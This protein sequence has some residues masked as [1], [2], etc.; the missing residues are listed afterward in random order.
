MSIMKKK[1]ELSDILTLIKKKTEKITKNMPITHGW[2]HTALVAH[3]AQL[4]ALSEKKDTFSAEA[5]GWTHDWGRSIEKTDK[6]KRKH[7]KLSILLSKDFYHN[8][9]K[10]DVIT[11]KQYNDIQKAVKYHSQI[12]KTNNAILKIVRD[13]DRLSRFGAMGL[14]HIVS[15]LSK[16]GIPFYVTGQ[17]IIRP[18]NAPMV[19]SKEIKCIIDQINFCLDH[20]KLM[21][22][23]L[24]KKMM[25]N[26]ANMN[27][28]F[29]KLFS[30]HTNLLDVK[31]WISFLKQCASQ[32]IKDPKLFSEKNFQKFKRVFEE[33]Q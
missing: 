14:Y 28:S 24:A 23:G 33:Q 18:A 29:L 6:K 22:I 5:A 15:G 12:S 2:E 31:L 1:L 8:L 20:L 17:Q 30:R 10:Q 32:N 13:A 19:K 27:K 16:E 21:E 7:A 11:K 25:N 26:L 4:L 9:Y 3:Y